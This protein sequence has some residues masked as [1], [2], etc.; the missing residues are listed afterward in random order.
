MTTSN[1][2]SPIPPYQQGGTQQP[3]QPMYPTQPQQTA[4]TQP[5]AQTGYVSQQQAQQQPNWTYAAPAASTPATHTHATS[6]S[7][8]AASAKKGGGAKTF[9]TAFVG[10]GLAVALAGGIALSTGAISVGGSGSTTTL[11]SSSTSAITASADDGGD[12]TLA[13]QV[14]DKVLPSIVGIDVYTK[15]SSSSMYG[16]GYGWGGS[17]NGNSSSETL[18]GLGSGVI[19]SS[20]GY[21]LTNYHVVED[22][23]K[24][25]VKLNDGSE[26]EATVVGTDESSDLAVLKI[27]ASNLTAVEI[28]SSENLKAGQWVMTAGSPF[29]LEQSVATGIVSATSRT[30]TVSDSDDSSGY[31][32]SSNSV[33]VY[34]NMIQTDAAI[35]PGNSGG[36]LVND[37]GQLIGI[38]SVIESYSGSYS[39]VGFA[40]PIDY[41]MD[42]AQQIINGETPSHASLGVAV[43]SVTD[44]IAQRYNLSA[45]KGAYVNSV[46]TGSSA[47]NAGL[48]EGDIITKVNDSNV[49]SSTDLIAAV[50][51]AGVGTEVTVTYIR[52]GQEQATQATLGSDSELS[53]N[54]G[55]SSRSS[56]SDNGQLL[57]GSEESEERAAA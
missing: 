10:A 51:T 5:Q 2:N 23:S 12:S 47:A 46:Y 27:D 28:G 38:N 35:N 24:L 40:I 54:S 22:A 6:A 43:V 29:G 21:I 34:P 11:G 49:E 13:E 48:Q 56:L 9:F 8:P 1:G 45:D 25:E 33:S 57:G 44:S 53:A 26:Y 19:I 42:I 36:A 18:S 50:R 3:Q 7:A 39:G 17:S 16:F 41:A 20:D 30:I 4:Y 55:R 37:Q 32:T 14:A 52:D 31:S 15:Q